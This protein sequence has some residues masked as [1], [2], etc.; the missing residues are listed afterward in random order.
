[1][2]IVARTMIAFSVF[3]LPLTGETATTSDTMP[4]TLPPLQNTPLPD[5]VKLGFLLY[6]DLN[7][8]ARR[9]TGCVTCHAHSAGFADPRSAADPVNMPVSPGS[10]PGKF[11]TRNAQTAAYATFSPPFHWDE[12]NQTYVGGQ[13]W[14]GRANSLKDQAIGPPL[15]PLEMAM[16]NKEAVLAR[17]AENPVYLEAFR[18]LYGV[19]LKWP[20][21]EMVYPKFG[22]AIGSFEPT[23]EFAEFNS[24]YD[25]YVA[26]KID[27]TPQEQLGLQLFNGKAKCSNCHSSKPPANYPHALFTDFT[28][29]NLGLP[30]NPRIAVLHG[31]VS[32]P[33]D[34]GLGGRPEIAAKHPDGSQNGKFKVPT[35]RNIEITPPYGHNGVFATLEQIVH[36]YNTRDTLGEVPDATDPNFG[37]T[38]WPKPEV[39][40]NVNR[41]ELGNLGLTDEEE[42][43]VVAFLKTLTDDAFDE[44][45][46]EHPEGQAPLRR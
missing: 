24:K 19:D 30:V 25:Y 10:E 8:S 45:D 28:Y 5:R 31:V 43:A 13:F 33:L 6:N 32:L 34:L 27:L 23:D 14:D 38:G 16:P 26:S 29:D 37:I 12:Q 39:P 4:A 15:N 40:K 20:Q 41:A 44:K 36:F 22:A 3:V 17:L 7:I 11:G 9:N 21:V 1:M 2:L 46:L 35:L 42:A 18:R